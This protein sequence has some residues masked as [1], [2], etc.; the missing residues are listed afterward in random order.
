MPTAIYYL[1]ARFIDA[2]AAAAALPAIQAFV[3]QGVRSRDWWRSNRTLESKGERRAFWARFQGL[4]P[5]VH[6]YLADKA[7]GD[8][9]EALLGL[10]EFGSPDRTELECDGR[11][12]KY[13]AEVWH[14]TDW[15]PMGEFV[16][17]KFGALAYAWIGDE[18]GFDLFDIL[19]P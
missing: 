5:T 10:L 13:K 6:D 16:K 17:R 7:G 3:E 19:N 4:F 2:E 11:F 8:C 12:L 1:K 18:P 14:G 9:S 15:T